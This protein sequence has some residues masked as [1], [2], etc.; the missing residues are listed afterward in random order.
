M[1]VPAGLAVVGAELEPGAAPA[2][3]LVPGDR[4]V[5]LGVQ[6]T[7]LANPDE[8]PAAIRLAQGSIWAV[9]RPE[10][11]Y[12]GR[13]VVSVLVPT[14]QQGVVAQAAA[15]GRLRLALVGEG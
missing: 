14:D 8:I 2:G 7:S 10:A 12:N 3:A 15:D 4:V 1:A 13:V 5:L 11:T 6:N 9:E